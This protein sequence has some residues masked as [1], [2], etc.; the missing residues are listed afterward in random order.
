MFFLQFQTFV[1]ALISFLL[2]AF[3]PLL[4]LSWQF[5]RFVYRLVCNMYACDCMA[6]AV[7]LYRFCICHCVVQ[8]RF[9]H[10]LWMHEFGGLSTACV[11]VRCSLALSLSLSRFLSLSL[12]L[13]L[14]SAGSLN[15]SLRSA[16]QGTA[17]PRSRTH[18][19][20]FVMMSVA[21]IAQE[22]A[23]VTAALKWSQELGGG[24]SDA[25]SKAHAFRMATEIQRANL[26]TS[27]L[28]QC[29]DKIRE[30]PFNPADKTWLANAIADLLAAPAAAMPAPKAMPPN[31][32][33]KWQNCVHAL[34]V[35]VWEKLEGKHVDAMFSHLADLGLYVPCE[36][37]YR[38]LGICF[39]LATEGVERA[40]EFNQAAR[41]QTIKVVKTMWAT[42]KKTQPRPAM[43][44]WEFESVSA[45]MQLNPDVFD[46]VFTQ[47]GLSPTGPKCS[48]HEWGVLLHGTKCRG[49]AKATAMSIGSPVQMQCLQS[50][51]P[52]LQSNPMA[53]L[54]TALTQV[55]NQMQMR[56]NETSSSGLRRSPSP[57]LDLTFDEPVDGL[58]RVHRPLCNV[59]HGKPD[60][61]DAAQNAKLDGPSDAPTT[62][63]RAA[64]TNTPAAPIAPPLPSAA[65]KEDATDV[66]N[67]TLQIEE[68]RK[69]AVAKAKAMR[70]KPAAADES[71]RKRPSAV[72][73][74]LP[75]AKKAKDEIGFAKSKV[76]AG[77]VR[78]S[79]DAVKLPKG[80]SVWTKPPRPDKYFYDVAGAQYRSVVSVKEELG[81]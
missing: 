32:T 41:A 72:D 10:R 39:L 47:K 35:P 54:V 68:S 17:A 1:K 23:A 79:C 7:C 44:I 2:A 80:W 22:L 33:Q 26:N 15:Q 18:I 64:Q 6:V 40:M 74:S 51:G 16:A 59:P 61:A 65:P 71:M 53:M 55:C 60:A 13:S 69:A 48:P 38:A 9:V 5:W 30:V 81:I 4:R 58:A 12:S 43:V 56:G 70:K 31:S 50:S 52:S 8:W 28:V 36:K 19:S 27:D 24:K 75:A 67:M 29:L 49:G 37:T 57:E 73:E 34:T 14:S 76:A 3:L 11:S 62:E 20:A 25:V 78:A 45:F 63:A 42:F 21:A 66:D 77:F 46:K